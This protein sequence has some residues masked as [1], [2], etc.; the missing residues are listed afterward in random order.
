MR[1]APA[2]GVWFYYALVKS[3]VV[4]TDSYNKHL[5]THAAAFLLAFAWPCEHY[6]LRSQ[7]THSSVILVLY[8]QWRARPNHAGRR[9]GACMQVAG[10]ECDG[11]L[12]ALS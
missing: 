6:R 1:P 11:G 4:V 10:D 2:G 9:E 5:S 7:H 3:D 12:L 8:R